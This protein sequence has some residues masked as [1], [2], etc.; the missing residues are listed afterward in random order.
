MNDIRVVNTQENLTLT[1]HYTKQLSENVEDIFVKTNE[2][3]Q[4]LKFDAK[5]NAEIDELLAEMKRFVVELKKFNEKIEIGGQQR[6][7]LIERYESI[8][9]L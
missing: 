3:M 9:S 2:S 1:M 6:I 8:L 5:T 7:A 4:K